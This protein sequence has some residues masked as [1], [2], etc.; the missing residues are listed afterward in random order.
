MGLKI[1]TDERGIKI[2]RHEKEGRTGKF[3]T[4]STMVSSKDTDGNYINGFIDV[5]F[6]KGVEVNDKAVILVNNAFYIVNEYNGK[7]YPKLMIT[8]FDVKE[9]GKPSTSNN[10]D[11]MN[12]PDGMQEELPFC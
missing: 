10:T 9:E 2:Y 7:T 6:K 11:F 12:I 3:Y 8:D 4:Y 5:V 1:T